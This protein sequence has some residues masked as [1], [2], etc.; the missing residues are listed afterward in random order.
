[1]KI[2]ATL[3][4]FI[5]DL[6]RTVLSYMCYIRPSCN[7]SHALV[8]AKAVHHVAPRLELAIEASDVCLI[9][10]HVQLVQ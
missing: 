9:I 1:M 7:A 2:R 8:V 5:V 4:G 3:Y 6:V 10:V